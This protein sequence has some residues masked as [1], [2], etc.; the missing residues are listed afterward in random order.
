MANETGILEGFVTDIDGSRLPGVTVSAQNEATGLE[1]ESITNARAS[2]DFS[3]CRRE[4]TLSPLHWKG[5]ERRGTQEL[6]S[7]LIR[8]RYLM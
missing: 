1:R 2:T 7:R 4:P 8:Q 6:S 5:F 3:T